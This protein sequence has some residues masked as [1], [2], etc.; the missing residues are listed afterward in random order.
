MILM[1]LLFLLASFISVQPREAY[2]NT[3]EGTVL[4]YERIETRTGKR[5]WTHT[6]TV[7]SVIATPDGGAIA[8]MTVKMIPDNKKVPFKKP[9]SSSAVIRPDGTAVPVFRGGTWA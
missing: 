5:W 1:I 6:E 7:D 9:V 3:S 8:H 4:T 2:F